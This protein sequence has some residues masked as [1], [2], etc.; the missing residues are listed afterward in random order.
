MTL[1]RL[2]EKMLYQLQGFVKPAA[3]DTIDLDTIHDTILDEDDG[4]PT[5]ADLYKNFVVLSAKLEKTRLKRWPAGW[6]TMTIAELAPKLLP[7]K[8]G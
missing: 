8:E 6:L 4:P 1:E 5:T 2:Q 3:R 7:T